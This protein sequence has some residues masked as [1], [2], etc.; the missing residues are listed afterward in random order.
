MSQANNHTTNHV[1]PAMRIYRH[2]LESIFSMLELEDLSHALVVSRGWAAAVRSMKPINGTISRDEWRS[3]RQGHEFRPLPPIASIVASPLLRHVAAIQLSHENSYATWI[4][5]TNETLALLAQHAP[6][7]QSLWCQLS[8]TPDEPLMWPVKLASLH[9]QL[10]GKYTDA[11]INGVLQALASLPLLSSLRL[12]L[13]SFERETGI[14]LNLLAACPSL[15][16]FTLL[17]G[18]GVP[19]L[20]STQLEQIRSS[21]GHLERIDLGY[22]RHDSLARLLQ[23]PVTARW[24]DIGRVWADGRTGEL[25]LRLQSLTR[26]DLTYDDDV[27]DVDFLP[28]LPQLTA[29]QLECYMDVDWRV[30]CDALLSSLVRC[31]CITELDLLCG[32]D[33]AHW[34]ALFAK[35]AL[36]RLT[37]RRGEIDTLRCFASGPIT[38]T[39]EVLTLDSFNLPPS[40]LS[41]LSG[42]RRLRCLH[43]NWCFFSLLDAAALA[44]LIPP[45]SFL[46]AL[47]RLSREWRHEGNSYFDQRHGPSFER[48]QQRLTH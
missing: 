38:Q 15:T 28:Q 44:R 45:S 41:H 22:I 11:A 14:D 17:T 9:L 30:F 2:A 42:L 23:L 32:F 33:S 40:E 19:K 6:N 27:A 18:F 1:S 20:I 35:L 48:M 46:P 37:I 36:K 26:L 8:P 34:C 29:L 25:L 31:T 3:H 39:L 47:T 5:L 10:A 7:L 21:L 24:Q 16:D 43:L 12:A 4:P 13:L